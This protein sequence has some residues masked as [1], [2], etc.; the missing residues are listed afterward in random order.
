M[1]YTLDPMA[2]PKTIDIR[3]D[4]VNRVAG[5]LWRWASTTSKAIE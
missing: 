2:N 4:T 1:E 5:E 3:E